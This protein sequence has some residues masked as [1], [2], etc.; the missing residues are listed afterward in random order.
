VVAPTTVP[1]IAGN[2]ANVASTAEMERRTFRLY[3]TTGGQVQ[4]RLMTNM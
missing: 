2:I 3:P 4:T 1:G